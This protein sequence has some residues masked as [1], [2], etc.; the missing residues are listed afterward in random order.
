MAYPVEGDSAFAEF[1]CDDEQWADLSLAGIDTTVTGD[2]RV[3]NARAVLRIYGRETIDATV[4]RLLRRSPTSGG[5]WE[6]DAE[7]ALC[8]LAEARDALFANEREREPVPEAGL[9]AAGR[10][11]TK[12]GASARRRWLSRSDDDDASAAAR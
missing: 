11:F 6:L 2:S 1:Y 9:T 4:A 8:Q 7:K 12:L 10:A 3:R 5:F